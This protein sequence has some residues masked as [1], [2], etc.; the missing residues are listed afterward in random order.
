MSTASIDNSL[1]CAASLIKHAKVRNSIVR[2]EVVIEEGAEVEDC[3]VMDY[4]RIGRG[5][6]LR[7][8]IV[9]RHNL[10]EAESTLGFDPERDRLD[11]SLSPGGIVVATDADKRGSS[12]GAAG[13]SDAATPSS[14]SSPS[15]GK[16]TDAGRHPARRRADALRIISTR[17]GR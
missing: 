8:A 17:R 9:D 13:V 5:A 7:R 6:R 2:R 11:H 16:T 4:S 15:R 10:I 3:I 14:L 1:L 12:L